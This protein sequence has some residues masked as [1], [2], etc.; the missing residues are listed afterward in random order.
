MESW[1]RYEFKG[2]GLEVRAHMDDGDSGFINNY[3]SMSFEPIENFN[4]FVGR[5]AKKQTDDQIKKAV[6]A[7]ETEMGKRLR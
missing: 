5:L 4:E 1:N 7:L 6:Y 3:L 2:Y